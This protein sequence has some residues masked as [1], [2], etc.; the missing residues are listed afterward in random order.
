MQRFLILC[1]EREPEGILMITLEI[2]RDIRVLADDVSNLADVFF[3]H[4]KRNKRCGSNAHRPG[5]DDGRDAPHD[6]LPG[7]AVPAV[8]EAHLPG[9]RAGPQPPP[10]GGVRAEC[11]AVMHRECED[12][13]HQPVFPWSWRAS[14]FV[15]APWVISAELPRNFPGCIQ[16]V[17]PAGGNRFRSPVCPGTAAAAYDFVFTLPTFPGQPVRVAEYGKYR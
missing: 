10:T 12:R 9:Y 3:R 13:V 8:Q 1:R 2:V 15:R 17:T 4:R 7:T 11:P 6:S 5:F 16:A 14:R